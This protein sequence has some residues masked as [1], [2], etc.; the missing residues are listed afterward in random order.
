MYYSR[1]VIVVITG[2]IIVAATALGA[3]AWLS[4]PPPPVPTTSTA[5]ELYQ[6]ELAVA[7]RTCNKVN[8]IIGEGTVEGPF[9]VEE[10]IEPNKKCQ[11]RWGQHVVWAGAANGE[12]PVCSCDEGYIWNN[13]DGTTGTSYGPGLTLDTISASGRCVLRQ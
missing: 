12:V 8:L 10:C 11:E 2:L 9:T 5:D 1:S 3:K 4:V 13:N 7:Q 6:Q